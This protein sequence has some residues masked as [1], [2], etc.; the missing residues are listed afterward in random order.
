MEVGTNLA[1]HFFPN[2]L[3]F[4]A[5]SLTPASRLRLLNIVVINFNKKWAAVSIQSTQRLTRDAIGMTAKGTRTAA[6]R[7][8]ENCFFF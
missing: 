8:R 2:M 6:V 7:H 5:A 4:P 3:L 1:H